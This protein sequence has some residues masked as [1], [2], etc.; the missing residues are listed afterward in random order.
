MRILTALSLLFLALTPAGAASR[1]AAHPF[2]DLD[3]EAPECSSGW[4]QGALGDYDLQIDGS[5][6]HSGRQSMEIHFASPLAWTPSSYGILQQDFPLA[7]ALGKTLRLTAFLRTE[8]LTTG[9]LEMY[10]RAVDG[11]G[12]AVA[13][14]G[15]QGQGPHG[16]TSWTPYTI[17][18]AVPSS[19]REVYFGFQLSGNGTVWIDSLS[20]QVD[21]RPWADGK[22]ASLAPPN[23]Q[24][25]SWL[26]KSA[27]PV[28][29]VE[30]GNGFDDLQRLKAVIGDA[31]IVSLGEQTHGTSEF[32]Q[33]KHRLVEFLSSEMGFT[34][35]AIEA[36]MPEAYQVNR[37]VLT[38]QGDPRELLK[39]MYFWT[40]NTQEVLDMILWMREFNRSGRGRIEFLGFDMQVTRVAATVVRDL[41]AKA[42]SGYSGHAMDLA[43]RVNAANDR[44]TASAADLAAAQELYDHL[45][46]NRGNYLARASREEVDWGI[47]NARIMLQ[48]MQMQAGT[49]SRDESMAANVDWILE[50]NPDAKIVLWAH[51]GHIARSPGSMG[52]YIAERYGSQVVALGFAFDEGSYNARNYL[53]GSGRVVANEALPPAPNSVETYLNAAGLPRFILDLRHVPAGGP[54]TWLKQPRPFREIGAIARRCSSYLTVATDAFDGLVWI[55]QSTPSRLLR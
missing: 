21:G 37:Y 38:G 5:Q 22:P 34:Q 11:E 6:A 26:R 25:L 10:G 1:P 14:A 32:F 17:E 48:A 33:M 45:A 3:F 36:N 53:G 49:V 16:D 8:G 9:F 42:E 15:L 40:W 31:R 19:A 12:K 2:L 43:N 28:A 29:T 13:S 20:V 46:Q 44:G 50:Q 47:Q 4:L 30:A 24:A 54:A 35:F 39:G 27:I 52:S 18:I 51:N 41:V 7:Q 23:R 55:E